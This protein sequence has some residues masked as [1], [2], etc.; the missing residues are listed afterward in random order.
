[1][2]RI[3]AGGLGDAP[4]AASTYVILRIDEQSDICKIPRPK[5]FIEKVHKPMSSAQ[6]RKRD[7]VVELVLNRA[8]VAAFNLLLDHQARNPI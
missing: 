8:E 3:P 6:N 4:V 1:M 7:F 2:P 5:G